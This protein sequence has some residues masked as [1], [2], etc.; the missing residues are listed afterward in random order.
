MMLVD[1]GTWD[2]RFGCKE[3]GVSENECCAQENELCLEERY[4][5][6]MLQL[7]SFFVGVC[8]V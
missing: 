7:Q 8:L 4:S 3:G 2:W 6:Y 5:L 1:K